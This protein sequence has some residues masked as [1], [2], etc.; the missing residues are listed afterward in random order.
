MQ[1]ALSYFLHDS[2]PFTLFQS[3]SFASV[4]PALASATS[5]VTSAMIAASM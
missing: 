2:H 1:H 3:P 4:L 5:A